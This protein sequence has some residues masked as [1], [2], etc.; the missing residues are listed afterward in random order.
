M[1][2]NLSLQN[3]DL[4]LSVY[5]DLEFQAQESVF[6]NFHFENLETWYFHTW[7]SP[8]LQ[9]PKLNRSE[10]FASK[11]RLFFIVD[12]ALEFPSPY[13]QTVIF[14]TLEMQYDIF[15]NIAETV[16]YDIMGL[17]IIYLKQFMNMYS[18]KL[19]KWDSPLFYFCR[20]RILKVTH[21]FE[22]FGRQ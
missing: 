18:L 16:L 9:S 2:Q 4:L 1:D 11:C 6:S 5:S 14:K 15:L 13:F 17:L 22:N 3:K 12:S 7:G 10:S 8:Y 19:Q 20:I 21:H